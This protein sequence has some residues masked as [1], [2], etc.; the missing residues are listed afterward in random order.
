MM[1]GCTVSCLFHPSAVFIVIYRLSSSTP[2]S[3][4]RNMAT[5]RAILYL[6]SY[7]TRLYSSLLIS[8]FIWPKA[9]GVIM[10]QIEYQDE[11]L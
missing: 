6:T 11:Y 5:T 7:R 4:I 10:C 9:K 1:A 3:F 2:S 8:G